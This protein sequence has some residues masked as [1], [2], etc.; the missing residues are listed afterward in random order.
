MPV[1]IEAKIKVDDLAPTRAKLESAGARL[2]GDFFETNV[3]FDTDDRS[4]L[5]ADKG[6]RVRSSRDLKS[7][8]QTTTVTFKGPRKHGPLKSR[9]ETELTAERFEP[10]V[11]LLEDLGFHPILTFEKRRQSWELAGCKVELDELPHLGCFVEIEGPSEKAVQRLQETLGL[12]HRPIVKTAYVGLMMTYLQDRG[13]PTRAVRF[14]N[15]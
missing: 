7:D 14:A 9:Q 3:I 11:E 15:R 5:A 8:E 10:A 12:G 13:E 4:L 2:R 6:L 1:E